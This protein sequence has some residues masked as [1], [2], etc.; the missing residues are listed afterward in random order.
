MMW[1]KSPGNF[2]VEK[3]LII[4]LL[5]AAFNAL[6]RINFDGILMPSLDASS[7]I[8]REIIGGRRSQAAIRLDLSKKQ[9]SDVSTTKKLPNAT[10]HADATNCY[11]IVAH[12]YTSLC[13]QHLRMD[14]CYVLVLFRNKQNMKIYL[15][16]NF[17]VS[18]SFCTS[19][20]NL[21]KVKFKLT[22]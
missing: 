21:F 16:T 22:E 8:P 2:T 19:D 14:L 12:A 3:S 9:I 18:T 4:L 6:C 20:A 13:A 5:E 11:V 7:T 15:R 17:G 10:T 1:E